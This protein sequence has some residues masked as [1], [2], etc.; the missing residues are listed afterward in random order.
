MRLKQLLI[1]GVLAISLFGAGLVLTQP[2]AA[3][4]VLDPICQEADPNNLPPA[5]K[6]SAGLGDKDPLFGPDG[7]LTKVV[8]ILSIVI[9]ATA[10]IVIIISGIKFINS[11]GD[12]AK[13]SSAR[14]TIVYASIG[15]A[16][17]VVAQIVVAFV[18]SKLKGD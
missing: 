5:C 2:A 9:G 10:L 11:F 15:L 18:L 16:V 6:D 1:G 13:V 3:V 17:A 8:R 14:Q 7:V 12:P 4:D